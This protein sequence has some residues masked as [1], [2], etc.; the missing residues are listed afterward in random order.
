MS[1][2][3]DAAR[4]LLPGVDLRAVEQLRGG[5]RSSVTRVHATWPGY[6]PTAVIVKQFW[7]A[8]EGWAREAAALSVLASGEASG[9]VVAGDSPPV[10]VTEDLGRGPS[11]ADALLGDDP[12]AAGA[13]VRDWAQ[14]LARL[15][16][17]GRDRRAR[18]RAA[19]DERQGEMPIDECCV[20]V[21][22]D[23]AA[24]LLD[25]RCAA[26]G[27]SI[28]THA[29]DELRSLGE[30]LGDGPGASLSPVDTC[31]DN[32]VRVD[33]RV[34]LIDFEGAQWR[35]VAWDVAYLFVPWPTC[36]CSW[37]I[38]DGVASEAFAAYRDAAIGAFPEVAE[39]SFACDVEAATVGW[40]L[41]STTWF[42]D[43]A[44]G[45]DPVLNPDKPTPTRRAMI[46]HRLGVAARTTELPALAELAANLA[47]ELQRR[48]GDVP[49][50]LAQAF[51]G[52]T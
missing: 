13:A 28:P 21:E 30:R 42:L 52:A 22:L 15:H 18:F 31:P 45:S 48:W 40:A 11:L 47:D 34:V 2:G 38:P 5:E 1:D 29:L 14:A 41:T 49:L 6:E 9:L 20:G 3:L 27:V 19:L 32:N 36:W 4:A 16:S 26:L 44:L 43:N 33:D 24:R 50:E 39:E 51:A 23:D 35:H 46:L 37:R 10:V 7:Q 8:G 12:A 25:A 17:A